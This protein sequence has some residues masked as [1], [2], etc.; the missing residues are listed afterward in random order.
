MLD[1]DQN[2]FPIK[3]TVACA[4]AALAAVFILPGTCAIIP[5]GHRGVSVTLGKVY[6]VAVGEGIT[7]KK[8]WIE[9]IVEQSIQQETANGQTACFSSDLQTVTV[10]YSVLWRRPESKVVEL[11]QQ[12]RG[13]PYGTLVEPRLHQAIKQVTALY[14]AEDIAKQRDA[15]RGFVVEALRKDLDGIV[16]I[17]DV[18]ITN[19]DLSD[20]LEHAIEQKQVMQQQ[21]LAK[22]YELQKAEK[23]AEITV[24][25]ATAE[26][27]A[28]R[29]K[30][31]A[32]KSSPEV[33]SLEIAKKWNGV[34]PSTVVT[35][36]GGANVLLPL[37]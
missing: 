4:I 35:T 13:D 27:E 6:P 32:L 28:V 14:T 30:G 17:R 18:P 29:I 5:P 34:S 25:N 12:Y 11:Y 8:P 16:D 20:E 37:K 15:I 3:R 23:E 19:I 21:A 10:S 22:T 36:T 1:R 33:I 24:V 9:A 7:L 26:A 31:E 2:S